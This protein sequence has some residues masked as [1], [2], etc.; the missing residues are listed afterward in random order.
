[1]KNIQPAPLCFNRSALS[2]RSVSRW[3]Y[4]VAAF[5]LLSVCGLRATVS[6]ET[7]IWRATGIFGGMPVPVGGSWNNGPS[8]IHGSGIDE[9]FPHAPGDIAVIG[10]DF[11]F[12]STFSLN[13]NITIQNLSVADNEP[14]GSGK[15]MTIASGVGTSSLTF[16]SATAGGGTLLDITSSGN[17][18][19]QANLVRVTA[20]IALGGTS[21]L[22]IT[23]NDNAAAGTNR[24]QELHITA[25]VAGGGNALTVGGSITGRT[26]W[27]EGGIS[28]VGTSLTKTGAF[29]LLLSGVSTYAGKTT[30]AGGRIVLMANGSLPMTEEIAFI[31]NAGLNAS[32]VSGGL[33]F[34]PAQTVSG[35]GSITAS[36]ITVEGNVIPAG[37]G[38]TG[39]LSFEGDLFFGATAVTQ[40]E[41]VY[42]FF[43]VFP[44]SGFDRIH[45]FGAP[46]VVFDGALQL[47]FSG[48]PIPNGSSAQ[49]FRQ[50]SSY[51][52]QFDTVTFSGLA[53]N[54]A[55]I[56]DPTNGFVTIVPA[57]PTPDADFDDDSDVDGDDFLT[58]Q[59]G[60]GLTEAAATHDAGNADRDSDIDDADLATWQS[61]FGT[62]P[63]TGGAFPVPEPSGLALL[64][65]LACALTRV[66]RLA[67]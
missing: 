24:G 64:A 27:I 53:P 54:Q 43:V 21:P 10:R 9:L 25:G 30:V 60:L 7:F 39:G 23:N 20:P 36:S 55:A 18:S 62:S 28:G 4:A 45:G 31:G 8:W 5:T 6:A 63:S 48:D 58:W 42:P 56:F 67:A 13:Q 11:P 34:G 26:S 37:T 32:A 2:I 46:D 61:Q 59:R 66:R 38:A 49:I 40:F 47:T 65:G 52:G 1:M 14:S 17:S 33:V 16:Q 22:T 19:F 50:Y 15:L 35:I 12:D 3:P 51:S 57:P 44:L 41:F 29:D